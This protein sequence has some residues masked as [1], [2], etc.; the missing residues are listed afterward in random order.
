MCLYYFVVTH[1]FFF[2]SSTI[3]KN[4]S[5]TE[6]QEGGVRQKVHLKLKHH[7]RSYSIRLPHLIQEWISAGLRVVVREGQ[8][9]ISVLKKK[10]QTEESI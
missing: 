10:N 4:Y 7:C 3:R 6:M 1:R 2:Q 5:D 9:H 8:I